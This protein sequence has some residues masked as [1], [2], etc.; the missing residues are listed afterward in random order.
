MPND[1]ELLC[2]GTSVNKTFSCGMGGQ[3]L[4]GPLL[5]GVQLSND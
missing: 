3:E 2:L 4:L 1:L 5:Y